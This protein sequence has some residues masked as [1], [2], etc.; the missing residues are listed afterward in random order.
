MKREQTIAIVG[1]GITGLTA[2]YYLQRFI[3]QEKL[4]YKLKLIE[5][6]DRIGG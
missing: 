3:E 4:P 6:N 1:A 2:A 5:A